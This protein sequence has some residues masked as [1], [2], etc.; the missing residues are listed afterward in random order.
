MNGDPRSAALES[1][2]GAH[3]AVVARLPGG[4]RWRTR[5]AESLA[6]L[7]ARGLPTARDESWRYADLRR[8]TDG[9]VAAP[10]AGGEGAV[11]ALPDALA[12][13]ATTLVLTDG[14]WQHTGTALPQGLAVLRLADA[15]ERS[16]SAERLRQP[17]DDAADRLALLA[18][19]Y[20]ANG[21]VIRADRS[22]STSATTLHLVHL[23]TAGAITHSRLCI[24]LEAGAALTLVEHRVG[25][26]GRDGF[27]NLVVDVRIDR[28]ASLRHVRVLDGAAG[29]CRVDTVTVAVAGAG[30]YEHHGF[31]LG[32]SV[33]R[34]GLTVDLDGPGAAT[35]VHGLALVDG[36]RR[37]DLE[38]RIR[39]Q[40]PGTTSGHVVRGV[41]AGAGQAAI[42]SRVFV[43]TGAQRSESRQSLRNLL[44]TTGAEIDVR[45]QLEINADDVRC[46]HGATTGSLDPAQLFYLLS[47]GIDR[48][49]AQALLTFAFCEDVLANL[50]DAALRR[51]LE[52]RVVARL[53]DRD[54]IR[55]FI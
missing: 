17:G 45:P 42:N 47:R 4:E 33:C 6:R 27:A 46:S 44:L 22:T 31:E 30:R 12:T 53:P 20:T 2:R 54:V 13:G 32:G 35:G 21:V 48:P 11:P 49:A 51:A 10:A 1:L 3:A 18:D 38:A 26:G 43:A 8:I 7:L 15:L 50:P 5:R 41:G 28:D 9:A 16:G 34:S 52:E 19:A 55:E 29:D 24:E 25:A 36:G 14:V 37:V 23:A 39:H 40:S